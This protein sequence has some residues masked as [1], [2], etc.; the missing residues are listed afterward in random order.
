[1]DW[2]AFDHCA[3]AKESH[4][5]YGN[6]KMDKLIRRFSGVIPNF[7]E[8][9]ISKIREQ[10]ADFKFLIVEKVKGGSIQNFDYVV[11]YVIRDEDLKELSPLIDIYGTFQASSA[12]CERGFSLMNSIKTKSRNRLQANHMDNLMR[13]KFYISF[14]NILDLDAIYSCWMKSK[15][16]RKNMDIND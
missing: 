11:A 16:R 1:M 9:L 4:F 15:Q 14:G 5:E 2:Q 6:D 12:D 13:I 7:H 8:D 10:Y 3:I